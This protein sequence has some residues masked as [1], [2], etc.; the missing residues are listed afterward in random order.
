MLQN[1]KIVNLLNTT[2]IFSILVTTGLWNN[3]H[4]FKINSSD[5]LFYSF[6]IAV[7][8]KPIFGQEVAYVLFSQSPH[9]A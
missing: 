4:T 9:I 1:K 7:L 5:I 3:L 2:A 8:S 6:L